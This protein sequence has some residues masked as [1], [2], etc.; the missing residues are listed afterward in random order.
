M[1]HPDGATKLRWLNALV[2]S[3]ELIKTQR[4]FSMKKLRGLLAVSMVKMEWVVLI[5]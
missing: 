2:F 3:C 4:F 5:G 1:F